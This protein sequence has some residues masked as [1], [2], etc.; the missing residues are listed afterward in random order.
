M[1]L[2]RRKDALD[3][4]RALRAGRPEAPRE[5]V[6]GIARKIDVLAIPGAAFA[7]SGKIASLELH[8]GALVLTDTRDQKNYQISF[9]A[10]RIPS[11]QD[12]HL[13]EH[14]S[15]KASYDGAH[16]FADRRTAD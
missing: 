8:A 5:L 7:F 12:L 11:S 9:D 10:A 4:E 2:W 3:L 6:E 14:V 13:G 16:Y 15:I 1:G